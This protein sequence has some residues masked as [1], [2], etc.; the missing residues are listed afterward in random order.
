[1]PRGFNQSP[2]RI[3]QQFCCGSSYCREDADGNDEDGS[4]DGED[5]SDGGSSNGDAGSTRGATVDAAGT[6]E[7]VG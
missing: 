3:K 2:V 1:M 5:A 6:I 7:V 4:D